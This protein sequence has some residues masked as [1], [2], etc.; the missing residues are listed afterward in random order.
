MSGEKLLQ[1]LRGAGASGDQPLFLR[2]YAEN[3]ISYPRAIAA[4]RDGVSFAKCL[5]ARDNDR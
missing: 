2:L 4:Y 1:A 3:R 5:E